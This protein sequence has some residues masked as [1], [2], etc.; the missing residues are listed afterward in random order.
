MP[1]FTMIKKITHK[2]CSLSEGKSAPAKHQ[3]TELFWV[4][5]P[6]FTRWAESHMHQQGMTP[7]R[8][9]LMGALLENGP[10]MMSGL[11]DEL[12][13]TATNVT[14]LVD[15]L[16]K[17]GMVERKSHPTD[18]RATMIKLTVKAEKRLKENCAEFKDRVS[19]LFSGFAETEKKQLVDLLLHVRNALVDRDILEISDV[20]SKTSSSRQK[21]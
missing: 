8:L 13:V 6:A 18:R 9:R 2:P 7:Q 17:D 3:L 11:K 10:M 20:A 14:A 4:L 12:G 1:A 15:V 21:L 19:E 16:E 5:G